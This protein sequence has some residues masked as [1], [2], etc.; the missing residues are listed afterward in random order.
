MNH[1]CALARQ[2][3]LAQR[4]LGAFL[5]VVT[6]LHGPEAALISADDWL[7]EVIVSDWAGEPTPSDWRLVTIA[8]ASRLA[9]RLNKQVADRIT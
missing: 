8:A 9:A 7:D 3:D 2:M 6:E 5:H 4:E 1:K